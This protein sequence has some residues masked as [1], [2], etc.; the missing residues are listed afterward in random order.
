M[1][2]RAAEAEAR[3]RGDARRIGLARP[4]DRLRRDRE[5][6]R[7]DVELPRRLGEPVLRRNAA[8]LEREQHLDQ[9]DDARR[10]S[11][12]AD[13]RLVRRHV[14]RPVALELLAQALELGEVARGRAGR[15]RDHP[16]D[17]FLA[18]VG[19]PIR[20][21]DRDA[22]ARR[23]R[24]VDRLA[25]AVRRRAERLQHPEHAVAV[26]ERALQALQDHDA[27]A[28]GE[29]HAVARL[30][31]RP[32]FAALR[33]P[34]QL[35]EQDRA[36]RRERERAAARDDVVLAGEQ[37]LDAE[38]DRIERRRARGVDHHVFGVVGQHAAHRVQA[39]AMR[40]ILGQLARAARIARAQHRIDLRDAALALVRRCA[41]FVERLAQPR[42]HRREHHPF[43][44]M[45]AAVRRVAD[46]ER[47]AIARAHA[48]AVERLAQRMAQPQG[49]QLVRRGGRLDLGAQPRV[50]LEMLDEHRAR[51]VA[52]VFRRRVWRIERSV[53]PTIGRHVAEQL[54]AVQQRAPERL[55][56]ARAGQRDA[57][58]DDGD[59]I[60]FV[61]CVGGSGCRRRCADCGA[62]RRRMHVMRRGC[63]C[64]G[65]H[66]RSRRRR[67]LPRLRRGN[68]VRR[69]RGRAR[70]RAARK[71]RGPR[72]RVR[73]RR[74][75]AARRR[76]HT[77]PLAPRRQR[78]AA[79]RQPAVRD[80]HLPGDPARRI[81]CEE[82]HDVREILGGREAAERRRRD[83]RALGVLGI[84]K[85]RGD[86]AVDQR[87]RRAVHA[88]AEARVLDG[89][90]A[91][92]RFERGLRGADDEIVRRHE[93]RAHRRNV[94]D[95]A[96]ARARH[97]PRGAARAPERA[98]QI[99]VERAVE[100]RGLDV[101]HGQQRARGRV[102]HENVELAVLRFDFVEHPLDLRGLRNRR[103][104]DVDRRAERAQLGR[105]LFRRV[106][107]MKEI[108]DDVRALFGKAAADRLSDV[109]CP[110]R[111]QHTLPQQIGIRHK[112]Q[113]SG[114]PNIRTRLSV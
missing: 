31:E 73:Q 51:L 7:F 87:R 42:A 49:R 111:H 59:F 48:H 21:L 17:R 101:V 92:Q 97:Q 70:A 41:G 24:R 12:M 38:V 32:H 50:G 1:A 23:I 3:H 47:R 63:A 27:R 79:Q 81:G 39:D 26:G 103:A 13:E 36:A 5:A 69:D 9:R 16:V 113:W 110:A 37:A 109:L 112:S 55:R 64:I 71:R 61:A 86:V 57:H 88:N 58:A 85:L 90:V 76:P 82:Q 19:L 100:V 46:E 30:V 35:R 8:V 80:N 43:F 15:V 54:G 33:K 94:D 67:R 75:V 95:R 6:A 14:H 72:R 104:H 93:R 107:R 83:A 34:V 114:L 20:A 28:V 98:L 96:T 66:A 53:I 65:G 74:A 106:E 102:V 56:I 99:R 11:G 2:V 25:L 29:Q 91:C 108:D 105:G 40:E 44:Q 52:L 62:R 78:L 22:L 68:R 10:P 18:H 4:V 77:A 60:G 89:Q 84:G 45:L